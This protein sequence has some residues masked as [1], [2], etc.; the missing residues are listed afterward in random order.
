MS[1][2]AGLRDRLVEDGNCFVEQPDRNSVTT[3]YKNAIGLL[4]NRFPDASERRASPTVSSRRSAS[5]NS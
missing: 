4:A 1:A 3:A 5:R 2:P